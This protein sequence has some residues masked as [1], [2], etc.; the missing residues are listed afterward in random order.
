MRLLEDGEHAHPYYWAAFI[1]AGD[2]RPLDR[3][4]FPSQDPQP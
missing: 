3:T 1:P 2:W 4:I